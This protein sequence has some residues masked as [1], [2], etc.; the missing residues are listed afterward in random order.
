MKTQNFISATAENKKVEVSPTHVDQSISDEKCRDLSS[1]VHIVGNLENIA[2]YHDHSNPTILSEFQKL[3]VNQLRCEVVSE[4]MKMPVTT[5]GNDTENVLVY[6]TADKNDA[7][8]FSSHDVYKDSQIRFAPPEYIESSSLPPTH[9]A[10]KTLGVKI[11]TDYTADKMEAEFAFCDYT[12]NHEKLLSPTEQKVDIMPSSQCAKKDST[13]LTSDETDESEN[14]GNIDRNKLDEKSAPPFIVANEIYSAAHSSSVNAPIV[15]ADQPLVS[16]LG[17]FDSVRQTVIKMKL[18]PQLSDG[19]TSD[20]ECSDERYAAV[21]TQTSFAFD[22]P[23]LLRKKMVESSTQVEEDRALSVVGYSTSWRVGGEKEKAEVP[24]NLRDLTLDA[25]LPSETQA[26]VL[27]STVGL[28]SDGNIEDD[29]SE[30]E[31]VPCVITSQLSLNIIGLEQT[32]ESPDS[33]TT[34][35]MQTA[36]PIQSTSYEFAN[37][38]DSHSKSRCSEEFKCSTSPIAKLT[39]V[40]SNAGSERKDNNDSQ[41]TRE[42]FIEA[43]DDNSERVKTLNNVQDTEVDDT[44]EQLRPKNPIPPESENQVY[45]DVDQNAGPSDFQSSPA[46]QYTSELEYEDSATPVPWFPCEHSSSGNFVPSFYVEEEEPIFFTCSVVHT[47]CSSVPQ[48]PDQEAEIILASNFDRTSECVGEDAPLMPSFVGGREFSAPTPVPNQ[49]SGGVSSKGSSPDIHEY[50]VVQKAAPG[51]GDEQETQQR[52]KGAPEQT[53]ALQAQSEGI[54]GGAS[55]EPDDG[56]TDDDEAISLDPTEP[57][58]CQTRGGVEGAMQSGSGVE[59][60]SAS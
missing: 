54:C 40:D 46:S 48:T 60:V 15:V 52:T 57:K 11:P 29:A 16:S 44:N 22:P 45:G 13:F 1:D 9:E 53:K 23:R 39:S 37:L 2:I 41:A 35:L 30:I 20:S 36:S 43:Y 42:I 21:G 26:L 19:E 10:D 28:S 55:T 4:A 33:K 7:A 25:M 47:P 5:D 24:S 17:E 50:E 32:K 38:S 8:Q 51:V 12:E 49:S 31:S 34:I 58:C 56:Q 3:N 59:E 18:Q 14:S 6:Y 27:Q